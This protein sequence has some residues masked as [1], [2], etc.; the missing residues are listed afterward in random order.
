MVIS[1]CLTAAD[2]QAVM[3]EAVGGLGLAVSLTLSDRLVG[4]KGHGSEARCGAAGVRTGRDESSRS[5]GTPSSTM[6]CKCNL[7]P[8]P[9]LLT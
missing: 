9:R 4:G 1:E 5:D 2:E 7:P 8:P 3:S 6:L